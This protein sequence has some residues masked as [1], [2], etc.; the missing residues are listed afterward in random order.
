LMNSK[1]NHNIL[2]TTPN[3]KTFGRETFIDH[4]LCI[5]HHNIRKCRR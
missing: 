5:T 2:G 3:E 4:D 1:D